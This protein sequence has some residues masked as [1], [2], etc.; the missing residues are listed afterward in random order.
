MAQT[1]TH[2]PNTFRGVQGGEP[3]HTLKAL[4]GLGQCGKST[5]CHPSFVKTKNEG[6]LQSK[7]IKQ[8]WSSYD[9][10]NETAHMS[11]FIVNRFE[12]IQKS[13]R[14]LYVISEFLRKLLVKVRP[15]FHNDHFDSSNISLGKCNFMLSYTT[16]LSQQQHTLEYFP[17]RESESFTITRQNY[18]IALLVLI[19]KTQLYLLP[20]IFLELEQDKFQ[21][22]NITVFP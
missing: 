17:G 5:A 22:V 18:E 8:N 13:T 2:F 12:K 4:V 3:I 20:E 16:I 11:H 1:L 10:E 14:V 7:C 6:V 15:S 21:E 9:I 19:K